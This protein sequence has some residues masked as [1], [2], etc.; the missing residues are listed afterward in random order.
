MLTQSE[1]DALIALSKR[2]EQR[3]TLYFPVAGDKATLQATSLDLRESF[4]FDIARARLRLSKCT[5]QE[6]YRMT[7]ILVRLDLDGP[8]HRNP[9]GTLVVCPHIH[10]Y[11]EG[12]A[13]KWAEALPPEAFTDSSDLVQTLREFLEYCHVKNIPDIQES[14]Q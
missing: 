11:R 3:S 7:E 4:V 14:L 8:P 9:D 1:A 12:F 2:L 13:D 5:Y 10:I 6:R